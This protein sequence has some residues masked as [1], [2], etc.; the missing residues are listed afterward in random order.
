MSQYI[1]IFI[2]PKGTLSDPIVLDRISRSTTTLGSRMYQDLDQC[3]EGTPNFFQ[4]WINDL[5][6]LKASLQDQIRSINARRASIPSFNNSIKDKIE[7]MAEY[8]NELDGLR[9]SIEEL[10]LDINRMRFYSNIARELSADGHQLLV[11]T[12]EYFYDNLR[13]GAENSKDVEI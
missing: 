4:Y 12:E 10:D 13:A 5:N 9:D 8:D 7:A 2:T 6:E 1:H 3:E 11:S